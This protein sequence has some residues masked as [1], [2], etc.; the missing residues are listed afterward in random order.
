[1]DVEGA[2]GFT[3]FDAPDAQDDHVVVLMT[4]QNIEQLPMQSLVRIRSPGDPLHQVPPRNYLGVV[5]AGPFAEPD[6]LRA[7]SSIV[8]ATTTQGRGRILL[9]RYHGR[10]F[11]QILGEEI[12]PG[13][14][15]PH[16]YRPRPNSPVFPLSINETISVLRVGGDAQLGTLVGNQ[17]ITVGVNT[18]L[19]S[20]LP[21]HTAILG[22]TG[23]GKSTT[24]ARL[25]HQLQR[26]GA[27][28]VIFDVEGEYTEIDQPTSHDAML[29]A[30][31]RRNLQPQGVPNLQ[32]YHLVGRQSSR[33]SSQTNVGSFR[34]DFADLSPHAVMEILDLSDAQ[35]TRFLKAYDVLKLLM[36]DL[37]IFPRPHNDADYQR[38]LDLDELESGY[39]E[40][41]L[42]MLRDVVNVCLDYADHSQDGGGSG[43][44]RSAADDAGTDFQLSRQLYS[45]Q[46][47]DHADRVKLFVA[48]SRPPGH[49]P[50]WMSLLGKLNRLARLNVFDNPRARPLSPAA[51]TRGGNVSVIDLS[52]TDSPAVNNLVIAALLRQIQL[53]QELNFR[54][55][56]EEGRPPTATIVFIEEA[57]EFLSAARIRQMPT[58]FE[59]VAR[60]AKRGRKRWLG[61]VF[62]TQLPQHLPDDILGLVNNYVIH[63]IADA[64]VLERLRRSIA[65]LDR[66]QW[67]AVPAL[68]PGQAIVSLTSATRPVMVAI[69]PAPCRL[70]LVE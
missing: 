38:L 51:L 41:T 52:D 40:M 44:R 66:A 4:S 28:V 18:G 1:V 25:V 9:P 36:R 48:R 46:L 8:V 42:A 33:Q 27:A 58:L 5:T 49:L 31:R 29:A 62:V 55:A 61:L 19:K 64:N 45:P 54:Q 6:G 50:S 11:V 69:D 30:L 23:S 67:G 20:V 16:R 56:A 12:E 57:H 34:L 21:R 59:Q 70:R 43:R 24:V 22:T 53:Q 35:Q 15:V 3:H 14:L 63:K 13:K 37:Q 2:L 17:Q 65:N 26:A 60:I 7:D 10:A 68:A 32:V 47:R 39:P